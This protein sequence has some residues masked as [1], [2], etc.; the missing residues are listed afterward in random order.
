MIQVSNTAKEALARDSRTFLCKLLINGTTDVAG[1]VRA[2]KVNKGSCGAEQFQIGAVYVPFI[3]ATIDYEGQTMDSL[4]GVELLVQ[5]GI[6]TGTLDNPSYEYMNIGWFTVTKPQV[7]GSLVY[8]TAY[9]RLTNLTSMYPTDATQTLSQVLETIKTATG[10]NYTVIGDIDLTGTVSGLTGWTNLEVLQIVAGL[11]GGYVTEDNNGGFV[12]VR[13]NE[14]TNIATFGINDDLM[15]VPPYTAEDGDGGFALSSSN[16]QITSIGAGGFSIVFG[17]VETGTADIYNANTNDFQVL[18]TLLDA[19]STISGIKCYKSIAVGDD[20]NEVFTYGDG[21]YEYANEYMTQAIFN[22]MAS[23]LGG[24]S[25]RA[26]TLNMSHGTPILEPWDAVKVVAGGQN[27]IIPCMSIEII[28][29][30][31]IAVNVVSVGRTTTDEETHPQGALSQRVARTLA[32]AQEANDTAYEAKG[33]ADNTAQ[34]FWYNSTGSDTGVHITEIP[35]ADFLQ[36]P[37]GGN[38][39]GRSNGIAVRD[40]LTE[41][42]VFGAD[43][44]RIGKAESGNVF[45]DEDSVDI[46]NGEEVL[47]S[48]GAKG[49]QIGKDGSNKVNVTN[50]GMTQSNADGVTLLDINTSGAYKATTITKKTE[51]VEEICTELSTTPIAVAH[52]DF[53]NMNA[54]G[55]LRVKMDDSFVLTNLGGGS[56]TVVTSTGFIHPVVSGNT[57]T[58]T[59]Y[60][61]G[62]VPFRPNVTET[63]ISSL[64]VRL[65]VNSVTTDITIENVLTY[66][67]DKLDVLWRINANN[68]LAYDSIGVSCPVVSVV[69]R[70]AMSTPTF[71]LGTALGNLGSFTTVIGEGLQAPHSNQ[72]VIGKYNLVDANN[73]YYM[74]VVGY[75]TDDENRANVLTVD[76]YGNIIAKG[77]VNATGWDGNLSVSGTITAEGHSSAIG[78]YDAHYNTTSLASGTSYAKLDAS[79]ITLSAGRYIVTGTA[80]YGGNANGYRAVGFCKVVNGTESAIYESRQIVNTIPSTS[81]RTYVSTTHIITVEEDTDI[82]LVMMQNSGSP[83]STDW[84]IKAMRIR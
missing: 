82:Y 81:W 27:F 54:L 41:L 1:S 42:S 48:F 78:W 77:K 61:G 34:Y 7:Q 3:T 21:L 4:N 63:S 33:I 51:A 14:Y 83:L 65:T 29:D 55:I 24:W 36:N 44:A 62:D 10:L 46:R 11:V 52:T 58:V 5:I 25:Y 8:I 64:V 38:L 26:G 16:W 49:A 74:L 2:L 57:I 32:V 50:T 75:G 6:N 9:G 56:F 39:L 43:G 84:Y 79:K 69:Y 22:A 31:G 19:E 67:D 47:S 70:G 66:E 40:G 45:T 15:T 53:G 12:L 73:A 30:G 59:G 17:E 20:Y 60:T 68:S 28:F 18:P 80:S 72:L 35:S 37:S 23:N 71:Q 13:F 76:R